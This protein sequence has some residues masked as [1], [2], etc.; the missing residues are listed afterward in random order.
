MARTVIE[1]ENNIFNKIANDERLTALSSVSK[2]AIYRLFVFVVAYSI[3]ILENLFDTHEKEINEKIFSQKTGRLPWY[4]TMALTYQYGFDLVPDKDYFDNGNASDEEIE[5]SKIIKYAAVNEA[6]DFSRIIVKIAGEKDGKL[7][8]FDDPSQVEAIEAYFEEIKVAGTDLTIINYKA[9]QL[10][11]KMQI[12][13]DVLILDQNGMS[14]L[15]ANYP[16]VDALRQFMKELDFNGKLRLSA[17]VDKVQLVPGVIDATLIGAQS[18]WIDPDLNGYGVPQP[19]FISK[20]A[21]S[22]YYEIVTFDDIEYVV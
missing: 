12:Q 9:D 8:D 18:S 15:N 2:V 1:I 11:L 5:A 22:G 6:E 21:E 10:Y 14:K 13:R 7:S 19:I 20:V 3:F 16:V 4:K 17:L